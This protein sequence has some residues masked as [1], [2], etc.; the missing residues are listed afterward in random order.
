M[1][2]PEC[3]LTNTFGKHKT[4]QDFYDD[5][6]LVNGDYAKYSFSD[7]KKIF[8]LDGM[9]NWAKTLGGNDSLVGNLSLVLF[10]P[11]ALPNHPMEYAMVKSLFHSVFVN[12]HD[13][14]VVELAMENM[15]TM[16]LFIEASRENSCK[17]Q[18][19]QATL[20]KSMTETDKAYC[21]KLQ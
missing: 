20:E 1:S 19:R 21:L 17:K 7:M 6:N 14:E 15:P 13:H 16:A 11:S 2:L 8:H 9:E 10:M 3:C 5:F 18:T 12:Q 4:I